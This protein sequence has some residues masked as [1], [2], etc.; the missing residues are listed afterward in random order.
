ML[1]LF[2]GSGESEKSVLLID[3]SLCVSSA[4]PGSVSCGATVGSQ[5]LHLSVPQLLLCG[6]QQM[7]C[8]LPA[9]S[10]PVAAM[11]SQVGN[12]FGSVQEQQRSQCRPVLQCH[13]MDREIRGHSHP[14]PSLTSDNLL[15][16]L[17]HGRSSQPL[18]SCTYLQCGF[19][20]WQEC[21]P[22]DQRPFQRRRQGVKAS[23][24]SRGLQQVPWR[25]RR[26]QSP[27][28]C[29]WSCSMDP[30]TQHCQ[31]FSRA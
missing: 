27:C 19:G 5:A 3:S 28:V 16:V 18:G 13:D 26:Q 6:T 1:W 21:F 10:A 2:L 9:S 31:R 30:H 23:R 4:Q 7:L 11:L 22:T 20:E 8:S 14:C 24:F 12:D 15:P 29:L 25:R 17:G